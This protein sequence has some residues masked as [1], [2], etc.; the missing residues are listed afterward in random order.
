MKLPTALE[1]VGPIAG[2]S[3]DNVWVLGDTSTFD[4]GAAPGRERPSDDRAL[5]WDG[6]DGRSRSC[7]PG[8]VTTTSTPWALRWPAREAP[9]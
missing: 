1:E 2:D 8:L 4:D 5:H 3:P 9:D 7:L 6:P